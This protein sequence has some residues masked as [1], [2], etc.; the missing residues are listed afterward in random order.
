[1]TEEE[2]KIERENLL[3]KRLKAF[4]EDIKNLK[5][6]KGNNDMDKLN[7]FIDKEIEKF[8][9]VQN[10]LVE[11]RKYNF[12]EELKI[13]RV[14]SKKEKKWFE[15]QRFLSYQSPLIFNMYKDNI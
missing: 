12:Y 1:M 2:K 6:I 9:Y 3:D 15:N 13:N 11:M 8:D 14:K 10:K 7:L 5:N 4:F